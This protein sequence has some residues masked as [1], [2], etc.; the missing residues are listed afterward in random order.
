MDYRQTAN[1]SKYD[2][3][4]SS[5]DMIAYILS[6]GQAQKIYRTIANKINKNTSKH[7]VELGC[8]P[9]S[10]IPYIIEKTGIS[11]QITGVD[12]SSKMIEIANRKKE[13]NNWQNVEFKC[14]DMYEFSDNEP[15]DTAIFCLALTSIP[16]ATKALEKAL[17]IL[18]PGG[19]L[20]IIDSIPLNFSWWH[21][22]TNF[23]IYLKSLIVGAKPTREILSFVNKNMKNIEIEE[24]FYGI[25]TVITAKKI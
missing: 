6:L 12:F 15:A 7:I 13:Y 17:S 18:K 5:Y 19:Q 21:P 24:M 14:M 2:F 23:Y 16:N 4:A 9:A 10:V 22:L 20:I 11:T 1:E 3:A 25:Y 8:G